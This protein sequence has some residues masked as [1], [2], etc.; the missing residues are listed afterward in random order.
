[1]AQIV[2]FHY[3]PRNSILHDMDGR[4]KLIC[5]ILFS[6]VI[7]LVQ[8]IPSFI[9]LTAGLILITLLAARL[10]FIT[11]LKDMKYFSILILIILLVNSFV[12]PGRPIPGFPLP[13]VTIEG[14]MTGLMA[15]W[16][17][18]LIIMVC[19]IMTGTTSLIT[20]KNVV[21]WYLRPI[22]L[23]PE[24]RI[25]TM[26]NLTFVFIPVIFDTVSEMLSA[27]KARCVEG[28]RNP[29]KRIMFIAFPL[30]VQTFRRTEELILAMEARCYS[31]DRTRAV[32]ATTAK[33]WLI[34]AFSVLFLAVI[35]FY[36]F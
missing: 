7:S 23:V 10:P 4:V 21:E 15:S 24:T 22:P 35:L 28:R 29:L 33:D 26:I 6:V 34:L 17:L 18:V 31:D 16:R 32:F 27:Q 19:A 30:L 1:M 13:G 3:F 2:L 11:L 9:I 36:P 25:A 20:L 12:I 8:S 14:V 5:M